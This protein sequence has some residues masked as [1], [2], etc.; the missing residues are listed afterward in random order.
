[1]QLYRGL[2]IVTN[3]ISIS[4]Q[5]GVPHHLLGQIGLSEPTWNVGRFKWEAN[6]CIKEIRS[7]GKLPIVVGGTHYYVN[8]LLFKENLVENAGIDKVELEAAPE[9][10]NEA[11]A[12]AILDDSTEAIHA[13]LKEVDPV[14]AEKWHPKD[15]RKIR[16]SLEIYLNTGR[17]A[18]DIYAEQL[19]RKLASQPAN[20]SAF[21]DVSLR[22]ALL[23]WLHADRDVLV[24]RLDKRVH[25]MVQRGLVDETSEMLG[26]LRDQ[27]A[28]GKAID[29]TTGIWQSIGLKEFETYLIARE[30]SQTMSE[31]LQKLQA[32]AVEDV[33][34][35]TRRY[36][37]SQERWITH[38]M[39]R[40]LKE[41]TALDQL[42]L[43]DSSDLSSW[44]D[45]VVERASSIAAKFLAGEPLP[46]PIEFS[47][48]AHRVLGQAIEAG[49]KK[50]TPCQKTCEVCAKTFVTEES[51]TE[52]MR[53]RTHQR[54][55]RASKRRALVALPPNALEK[56]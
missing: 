2:P 35:A 12:H 17:R 38:K 4:E 9:D 13:K 19:Q 23:F 47:E 32:A 41:E 53:S 50:I 51:W 20:A 30:D 27:Q 25:N 10:R 56:T 24:E 43:L 1:M 11:G 3:K 14:M 46:A 44:Q 48:T 54:M 49:E 26:Y 16:R 5:R 42:F 52:H 55:L 21:D 28:A 7:R 8:G 29:R 34:A 36:A 45:N 6:R 31:K 33:Q 37:K 40:A 39:L 15:R 18:S 22:Q